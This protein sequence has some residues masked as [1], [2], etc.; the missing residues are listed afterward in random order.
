M[1]RRAAR[2]ARAIARAAPAFAFAARSLMSRRRRLAGLASS[3]LP[4]RPV[5]RLLAGLAAL[6]LA[7]AAAAQDAPRLLTGLT[8]EAGP[9]GVVLAW[10]VDESRAGRIAGFTCV[11]RTP[12]HL[13]TGAPGSVACAPEPAPADSRTRTVAGLPE[14]GEYLFELVALSES[15]ANDPWPLRALQVRVAVTEALAGAAG[16]GRAVTGAGPLVEGCEP[17]DGAARPWRLDQTVSAAHLTH[18]PG[19][20]WS[21]GG[22]PDAA[23]EWPDPT[24]V[25]TLLMDAGLDPTPVLKALSGAGADTAETPAAG[26]ARFERA[27]AR[28]GAGT[29]ALLRRQAD[30]ARELKLHSSYPFGAAYLFDARHAVPGW[31]DASHLATWPELWNRA[32]CP[33]PGAP[34]A[35]HDVALALSDAAGGGRRL[36]HSGYGW[37]TVAPV[38]LHPERIVAAKAGLSFGAPASAPPGAEARWT[39]RLAG[40]LF[41]NK[42]RWAVA[43]DVTLTLEG[44]AAP[45]LAGGIDNIALAPLDAKSL[46]PAA[47]EPRALPPLAL[48]AAEDDPAGVDAVWTGPVRVAGAANTATPTGLPAADAFRGDWLAAVHGPGAAE[49]AG[50]LR[51]WT[52]LK[53]GADPSADWPAQAVLVAGFGAAR[54][55]R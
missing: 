37:W 19:R 35:T 32:N 49:A 41:H 4:L 6:A 25:M 8:A 11:Y 30:G 23:P 48:R 46:R 14:Y 20:G 40:H 44:G 10:T 17:E 2:P 26:E 34:G 5:P 28:A 16:P 29:K 18:Y 45:R 55:D 51:L 38:G 53:P 22:D 12:G 7:G 13:E 54:E 3:L 1:R 21:P 24:P 47:G 33:P 43:A 15:G 42:R 52:P 27:M 9:E 36:A 31:G 39:G 50:R